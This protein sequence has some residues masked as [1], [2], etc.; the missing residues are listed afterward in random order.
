MNGCEY[1]MKI[2]KISIRERITRLTF[3]GN[4]HTATERI[5]QTTDDCKISRKNKYSILRRMD[6]YYPNKNGYPTSKEVSL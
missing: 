2:I 4:K 6:D 5:T 3:L 1:S